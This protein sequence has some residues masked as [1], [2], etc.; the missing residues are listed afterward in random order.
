MTKSDVII[1]NYYYF[2]FLNTWSSDF[3]GSYKV[4][5]FVSPDIVDSL[6]SSNNLFKIFF[7]NYGLDSDSYNGYIDR[8]TTVFIATRL[9]TTDPIEESTE[10][11]MIYIPC[12]LV[13][14]SNSYAYLKAN[15]FIYSITSS[16]RILDTELKINNFKTESKKIIRDAIKTTSEFVADD[17]SFDITETKTLVTQSEYNSFEESR[18][19]IYSDQQNALI[20]SNV[21]RE[22]AER[23]LYTTTA[24]MKSA[25]NKYVGQLDNITKQLENIQ[26][27][28]DNNDRIN[29]ILNNVVAKIKDL[30]AY[31]MTI[32]PTAFDSV[33]NLPANYTA[34][35]LYNRLV[36]IVESKS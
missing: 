1:G 22:T 6:N 17:L 25:Y 34:E 23:K 13:D 33:S 2:K 7:D 28:A 12:T 26:T 11:T 29:N 36:E 32:N 30:L 35:Q 3:S 9:V 8:N 24:E 14:F 27:I 15:R 19:K 16:P 18:D 10:D 5:G 4:T 31:V 20:Q 21:N